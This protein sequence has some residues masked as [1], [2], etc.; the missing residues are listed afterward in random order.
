MFKNTGSQKWVVFAFQTEAGA[1]PGTPVT[2][3][4]ANITANLRLDG[5]V[6]NPTDDVN[7]D[8]LED[9][10]YIFGITA[11]E[12]NADNIV[13]APVS[14]TPFTTVI[15]VPGVVYPT[16]AMRGTDDALKPTTTGRTLDVTAT[17]EAG[18]DLD[19]TSG[20]LAAAQFAA[21]FL[22]ASKF[23]A[24][25][26]DAAAVSADFTDEVMADW[27]DGGRLDLLLDAVKVVTDGQGATGTGLTAMPWNAAWDA[28]VQSEVDDALDTAISELGVA[29]PTAT[30]SIRTG[31]M[32][33]YMALR[34]KR[35]TD[36]DQ[37]DIYNNAG[38]VICSA[39]LSD[40]TLE[41]I[42]AEY[43]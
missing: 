32:L 22:T 8:E 4:A 26:I 37:D 2:G 35:L 17:G 9:G 41:L 14:S 24:G 31:I 20:T 11:T 15:G 19:N 18:L 16:A 29:A 12:S 13:I 30:P 10:Y 1:S 42:K 34:N 7:P 27:E 28:E 3:D 23:A 40:D 36:A 25:A 5:A 39:V 43:A 21:G 6:A 33:G 38:A